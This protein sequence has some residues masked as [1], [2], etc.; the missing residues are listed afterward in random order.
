MPAAKLIGLGIAGVLIGMVP[1]VRVAMGE[2]AAATTPASSEGAS[3][4]DFELNRI[5]GEA[6]TLAK[7]KGK[8][9]LIV[10]VASR[11]G[12]TPQYEGLQTLY[13]E[14]QDEGFVVLGF[15]AN[16][17]KNQEPGSNEEIA[18]FCSTKFGVTFPLYEKVAV[19]GPEIHPLY[20]YLASR[21]APIGGEPRWNFTKF[22]VDRSGNVV[23]RYEPSTRPDD[24]TLTGKIDELLASKP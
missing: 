4:Y 14:K 18:N 10:N 19:M 2:D 1:F 8:V 22:L 7:Y 3:I 23:A 5:G 15:P 20:S 6:E 16:D 11:C 24:P 21:P 9:L 12:Y 17:F 13:K